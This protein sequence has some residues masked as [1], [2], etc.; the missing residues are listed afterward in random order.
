V[1]REPLGVF[2]FYACLC[3]K[4]GNIVAVTENLYKY[5]FLLMLPIL[6]A[7]QALGLQSSPALA[8]SWV[9]PQ[10]LNKIS[11]SMFV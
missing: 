7:K 8:G 11:G 10:T 2:Y 4:H 6:S 1:S 9:L 5:H 3:Q